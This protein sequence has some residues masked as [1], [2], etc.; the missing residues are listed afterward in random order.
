[1]VVRSIFRDLIGGAGYVD[2]GEYV[3][4]IC[5][6]S[7]K[8]ERET[9]LIRANADVIATIHGGID[10]ERAHGAQGKLRGNMAIER[11]SRKMDGEVC[12]S[13]VLSR[14]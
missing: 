12:I 14:K 6:S 5:L 13:N 2:I 3:H 8:K 10:V 4:E 7:R 11:A 1:M 9:H